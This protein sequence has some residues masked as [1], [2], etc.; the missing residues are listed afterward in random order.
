MVNAKLDF[1]QSTQDWFTKL[2][3]KTGVFL[4]ALRLK[5]AHMLETLELTPNKI[6]EICSYIGVGLFVGF[7]LKKYFRLVLFF[8]LFFAGL[9][10]A[11]SEFNLVVINWDCAQNLAHVTPNDTVG[12]LLTSTAH[13]VRQNLVIVVSSF[14]GF[15]VGYKIG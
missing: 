13:W 9:V 2:G 1:M 8:V 12:S 7:L 6:I 14:F 4:E 11:L 3:N 15:I 10:W 5:I